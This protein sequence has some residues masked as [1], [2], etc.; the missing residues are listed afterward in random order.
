MPQNQSSIRFSLEE[1]IW[2]KKGQ[3]VEELLSISLDPHIT[4]Q[5]RDQF[6]VIKGN[7]H[8]SGEYIGNGKEE[9]EDV[10]FRK[11]VQT[12]QYREED[13]VFEFYQSFPVDITV[14]IARIASLD[15]LDVNIEGFDYQFHGTDC[16]KINADLAIE[17]ILERE[18]EDEEETASYP[19]RTEEGFAD[20]FAE[21][22]EDVFAQPEWQYWQEEEEKEKESEITF[23]REPE[24]LQE[25]ESAES[26]EVVPVEEASEREEAE[27]DGA[28][29]S[30]LY[31][32]FMIEA[33]MDPEE[34][35]APVVQ[36][37]P[38]L[39]ELNLLDPVELP[40]K[41][42]VATGREEQE[43]V[44]SQ[45][46]SAGEEPAREELSSSSAETAE[47]E[48]IRGE[49]SSSSTESESEEAAHSMEPAAEESSSSAIEHA[50]AEEEE[51]EEK[52]EVAKKKKKKKSKYESISLTDFF[53]RKA[54]E[55]PAKLKVC[56]VQ[57][58][59]TLDQLAQ[60]YNINVQQILR[61]NHLD[62]NQDVHEGQVLY[63]P[64]N[65]R[66]EKKN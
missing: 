12:V 34:E 7:L 35:T 8:L 56:I 29:E 65:A 52:E 63:V 28:A 47:E 66:P 50:E 32:P 38:V 40:E 61:M 16:L 53:A 13:G 31:E 6:V 44:L 23:K 59:E 43:L 1:L 19:A 25:E 26:Y 33:H 49:S 10:L 20:G 41:E 64:A 5:E 57:N 54:E 17:G 60:K 51:S 46:E 30:D 36:Q 45:A 62:I 4:I 42:E 21:K 58:G 11:Y 48:L 15:V 2:F 22:E 24:N 37:E 9:G 14:P 3:E 18:E 39:K 27:E 55:K